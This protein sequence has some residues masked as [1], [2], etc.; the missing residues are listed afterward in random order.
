[1]LALEEIKAAEPSP[2]PEPGLEPGPRPATSAVAAATAPVAR[3]VPHGKNYINGGHPSK[4]G[5]EYW[6]T[7]LLLS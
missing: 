5:R 3:P 6:L 7:S 1:M 4:V 2:G